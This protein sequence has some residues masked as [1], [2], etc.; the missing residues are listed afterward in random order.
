MAVLF[1]KSNISSY[2]I[3]DF[4]GAVPTSQSAGWN[5]KSSGAPVPND[6]ARSC[7]LMDVGKGTVI[8]V[9]DSPDAKTNDDYTTITALE[10]IVELVISTFEQSFSNSQVVVT[11]TK[12]NGL[13]GKVSY[14]KIQAP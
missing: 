14:I 5:L 7:I 8:T 11:W 10:N 3:S 12:N 4:C 9:Y 1:Y 2:Q 13:D 6:T